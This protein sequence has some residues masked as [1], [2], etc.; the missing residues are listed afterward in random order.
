MSSYCHTVDT[1]I[2]FSSFPLCIKFNWF[3]SSD[4]VPNQMATWALQIL[5]PCTDWTNIEPSVVA[6]QADAFLY[7]VLIVLFEFRIHLFSSVFFF[8][9]PSAQNQLSGQHPFFGYLLHV[10]E[11]VAPF[12]YLQSLHRT[13]SCIILGFGSF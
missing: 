11:N 10:G 13:S 9:S 12:Q 6:F 7:D 5:Q 3:A 8:L 1:S 4:Y 2:G